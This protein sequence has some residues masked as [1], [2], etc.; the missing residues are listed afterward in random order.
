MKLAFVFPGQG[1]QSV[2]MLGSFAGDAVVEETVRAASAALGEDI[3]RLIADG[4]AADLDLTVNTQPCMLTASVA[5]HRAWQAAGGPA[6]A[7]VAGHSLGEYAALVVAGALVLAD[8]VPLVRF[9]AQAMQEAVPVGLSGM[10]A[11]LGL[12]DAAVQT[13]CARAQE[14]IPGSVVEAVNFNAPAQVVIAGHTAALARACEIA[15][16]LGAKR[17]VTLPVSVAFHSSL[18]APASARLRERLA[19]TPVAAPAIPVI[20]NID[21][22]SESDPQAIRD[23][24]ARQV[25]GPVRWSE[26]VLALASQGVT[27]VVECGPGKVLGGLNKRIA[28]ALTSL[29]VFDR[30]SLQE[31]L[32]TLGAAS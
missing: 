12:D 18:L 6:P 15:K 5:I 2:G 1:S 29:S 31:A 4:P 22:R 26:I 20:N 17:A 9:R 19:V 23:A 10:A 11:I 30:N 24:L 14:E 32:A 27:H 7:V 25:A 13:A 16:S 21:V 28:P 3:G 8:A